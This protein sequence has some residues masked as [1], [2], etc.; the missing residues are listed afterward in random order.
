MLKE[1]FLRDLEEAFEK[2]QPYTKK[3]QERE[4]DDS[5][6]VYASR[7]FQSGRP[8]IPSSQYCVAKLYKQPKEPRDIWSESEY[9]EEKSFASESSSRSEASLLRNNI[10]TLCSQGWNMSKG[11]KNRPKAVQINPNIVMEDVQ[12][13]AAH[14]G[15]QSRGSFLFPCPSSNST[16][17]KPSRCDMAPK[18]SFPGPKYSLRRSTERSAHNN[19]EVD[20]TFQSKAKNIRFGVGESPQRETDYKGRSSPGPVYI[21]SYELQRSRVC[22]P[23]LHTSGRNQDGSMHNSRPL[24]PGPGKYEVRAAFTATSRALSSPKVAFAAPR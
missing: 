24:S 19:F 14:M 1:D 6:F 22:S 7:A 13:W 23:S 15:N 16:S 20:Q 18:N 12:N 4:T 2:D 5:N 21:P 11:W 3:D 9:S 10:N 17:I 8:A